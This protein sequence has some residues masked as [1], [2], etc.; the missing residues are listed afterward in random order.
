M[1]L[2][3]GPGTRPSHLSHRGRRQGSRRLQGGRAGGGGGGHGGG[4]GLGL[5]FRAPAI[6]WGALTE[7]DL[8]EQV[9]LTL[10]SGPLALSM[11]VDLLS[12]PQGLTKRHSPAP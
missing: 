11:S 12:Q 10:R 8:G 1:R 9:R 3:V 7:G 4:F 2:A 6:G 5:L